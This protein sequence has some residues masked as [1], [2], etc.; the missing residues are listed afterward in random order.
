MVRFDRLLFF[1]PP[2]GNKFYPE[3]DQKGCL[4][5]WIMPDG[6]WLLYINYHRARRLDTGLGKI[7][8]CARNT[9]RSFFRDNLVGK[10]K[11]A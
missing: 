5:A 1:D 11:N 10:T 2:Y 9:C 3:H 7:L 8:Y 4:P 6:D